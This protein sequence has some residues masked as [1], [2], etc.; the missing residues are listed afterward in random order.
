LRWSPALPCSGGG[1]FAERDD[2]GQAATSVG[3]VERQMLEL[4]DRLLVE[5]NRNLAP[6]PFPRAGR[7][8]K[9]EAAIR[10][11]GQDSVATIWEASL[12]SKVSWFSTAA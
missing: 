6:F 7:G 2:G 8:Q 11:S 5:T 4:T 12:A 10:T 1:G 9:V 3:V